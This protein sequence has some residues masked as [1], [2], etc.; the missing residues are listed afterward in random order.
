M[1]EVVRVAGIVRD[2]AQHCDTARILAAAETIRGADC[3]DAGDLAALL[4]A[5]GVALRTVGHPAMAEAELW[6]WSA[7]VHH[8]R[9]IAATR[10]PVVSR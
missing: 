8:A 5:I 10:L 3:A 6:R 1:M 2:I 7:V 4:S 9:R